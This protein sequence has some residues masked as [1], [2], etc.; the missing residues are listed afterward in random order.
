ILLNIQRLLWW[1]WLKTTWKLRKFR[2]SI[3]EGEKIKMSKTELCKFFGKLLLIAV[4]CC[5]FSSLLTAQRAAGHAAITAQPAAL[6]PNIFGIAPPDHV[7]IVIEENHSFASII[8]SSSAPYIN[9]LAQ[10]GALFTQSFGVEHPS[11]PNY[12]DLFSGS[13]QGITDD[14]CPHTFSTENLAS[15]LAAAGQT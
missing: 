15:D 3:R 1:V 11:Q 14:T 5:T 13:N 7:V 2:K 12:L 9:S 10:Q 6:A 4:L 8:G